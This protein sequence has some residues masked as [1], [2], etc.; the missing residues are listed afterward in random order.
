MLREDLKKTCSQT[1]TGHLHKTQR[2]YFSNLVLSAV[3][4]QALDQ[5]TQHKITVRFK[6]HINKV[7][8]NN[9][10]NITQTQLTHDLLCRLQVILGDGLFKVTAATGKFTG[11]NIYH[12]HSFGTV[13]H[14][15][16]P[17]R[18]I[19]LAV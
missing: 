5:T 18:K 3:T 9:A 2:G 12:G 11:V 7:D 13:D 4:P 16:T 15:G 6:H 10:A 19:Y 1:F 8:N 17:R 14:Q